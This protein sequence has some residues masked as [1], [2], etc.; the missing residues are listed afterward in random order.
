MV[1]GYQFYLLPPLPRAV[2][3]ARVESCPVQTVGSSERRSRSRAG[4]GAG[5]L[6]PRSPAPR[7]RPLP[8]GRE[9]RARLGAAGAMT[10]PSG[11]RGH[12]S[13]LTN[14][15]VCWWGFSPPSPSLPTRAALRG[16]AWLGERGGDGSPGPG[17]R[18]L[19]AG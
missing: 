13:P 2:H 7:G 18:C 15:L 4:S 11:L 17:S 19:P 14:G 6:L 5:R 16:A 10:A 1:L 9:I 8:E 3:R 12:T